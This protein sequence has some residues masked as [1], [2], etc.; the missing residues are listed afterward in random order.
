MA[1]TW[2]N[3]DFIALTP[4]FLGGAVQATNWYN[5]I[6]PVGIWGQG[7]SWSWTEPLIQALQRASRR[8][9]QPLVGS[10]FDLV[11]APEFSLVKFTQ[12]GYGLIP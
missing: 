5:A 3:N 9:N 12:A 4:I 8:S 2:K 11:K 7:D 6:T 10:C 1:K